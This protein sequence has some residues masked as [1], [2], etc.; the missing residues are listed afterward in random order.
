MAIQATAQLA[1]SHALKIWLE[2]SLFEEGR[3]MMKKTLSL[4]C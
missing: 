1:L 3:E 4:E 2:K